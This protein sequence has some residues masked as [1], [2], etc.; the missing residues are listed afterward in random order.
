M[1][2]RARL[3]HNRRIP[4]RLGA[5]MLGFLPPLARGV[6]AALLLLLNTLFWIGPLLALALV[7]LVLP[8]KGV[9]LRIDPWTNAFATQWIAGNS[10]WTPWNDK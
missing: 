7:R 9:R 1:G 3:G 8:F 5:T 6:I 2:R 4:F 10:G